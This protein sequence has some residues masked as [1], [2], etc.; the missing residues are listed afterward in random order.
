M[1]DTAAGTAY[2]TALTNGLSG[3]VDWGCATETAQTAGNNNIT[4]VA[5]GATGIR[6]KYA[7]AQCR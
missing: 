7:P 1:R 4:V 3:A 2:A 6:A 5:L